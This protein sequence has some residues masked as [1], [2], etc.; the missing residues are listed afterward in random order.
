MNGALFVLAVADSALFAGTQYGGVLVST[1]N[2]AHW[3]AVNAG[4]T[5]TDVRSFAIVGGYLFA[6][7]YGL[8]SLYAGPYGG[9]IFK[10]SLSE[11]TTS[12][13]LPLKGLPPQFSLKQ[14]Y[15]NPFNPSTT[16][17]YALSG[18]SRVTL[19]VFNALGQQ[20]ATLVNETQD[21]GD[22][23]IR[24][25]GRDLASGI[26]FYRLRAGDLVQCRKLVYLR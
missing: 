8:G 14:N 2:A 25:D 10:R 5:T 21:S 19:S 16:I 24:F 3:T 15:P 4:L 18:R 17:R 9:G 12:V 13:D 1:D 23:E 7:T 20:V 26:Y 22:H 11:M 6:G